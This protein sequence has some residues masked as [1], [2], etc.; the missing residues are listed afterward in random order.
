MNTGTESQGDNPFAFAPN[1]LARLHDPKDLDVLRAMG[2][3]LGL[4][5]GLRTDIEKGLSPDE[6][7]FMANVTLRDVRHALEAQKI[8]RQISVK[9]KDDHD[10]LTDP[11][12]VFSELERHGTK[13]QGNTAFSLVAKTFSIRTQH[14]ELQFEDRR[15]IFST[16]RI[17]LKK[18]K[19]IFELM[20]EALHDRILVGL[21]L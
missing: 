2:G 21:V 13:P 6:G 3:I 8:R 11:N 10:E 12:R 5:F 1:Q 17:P 7:K 9:G 20:W 14:S 19:N 4:G 16:N 18:P 15:R